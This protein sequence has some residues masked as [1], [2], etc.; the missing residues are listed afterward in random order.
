MI[1][2]RKRF[3]TTEL[4]PFLLEEVFFGEMVSLLPIMVELPPYLRSTARKVT[5]KMQKHAKID[6]MPKISILFILDILDSENYEFDLY[7]VL[8]V[9]FPWS[10]PGVDQQTTGVRPCTEFN[11]FLG[12]HENAGK[13]K[14]KPEN[15]IYYEP[16]FLK[17]PNLSFGLLY[18]DFITFSQKT[19]SRVP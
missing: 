2:N 3:P 14:N 7:E 9:S 12:S 17:S 15:L 16:A 6:K 10:T 1:E 19:D 13:S 18:W 5:S 8:I 11:V 4:K